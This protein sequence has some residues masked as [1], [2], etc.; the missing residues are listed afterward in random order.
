MS[1]WNFTKV[2]TARAA[3]SD[4]GA[5]NGA[6][7][8]AATLADFLYNTSD[9]GVINL[10][11]M[12]DPA[13]IQQG[14]IVGINAA[15]FNYQGFY[16]DGTINSDAQK[17]TIAFNWNAPADYDNGTSGP[18]SGTG[19]MNVNS[20]ATRGNPNNLAAAQT[21]ISA[22]FQINELTSYFNKGKFEQELSGV[23]ISNLNQSDAATIERLTPLTAEPVKE[24]RQAE[25][26]PKVKQGPAKPIG[27]VENGGGETAGGAAFGN[28]R[29][30]RRRNTGQRR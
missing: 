24:T 23:L 20:A 3:V 16:P 11:I 6:N 30:G 13:W 1:P 19:L 7:N 26:T 8:P 5:D 4:K 22:A 17:P 2:P 28:P 29:L 21:K 9:M 14:E 27:W 18:Y 12:G 15:N 10:K 25:P